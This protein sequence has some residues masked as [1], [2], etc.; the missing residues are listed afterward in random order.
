MKRNL[1]F[2]ASVMIL[3][4]ALFLISIGPMVDSAS[5]AEKVVNMKIQS[6]FPPW[7]SIHGNTQGLRRVC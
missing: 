4:G 3:C 5:A 1:L 6:L 2:A 7:G